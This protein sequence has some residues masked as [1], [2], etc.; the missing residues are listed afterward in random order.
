MKHL[1]TDALQIL[2]EAYSGLT[3]PEWVD[4]LHRKFPALDRDFLQTM[5][6]NFIVG[7]P[8]VKQMD[9]GGSEVVYVHY[10]LFHKSRIQE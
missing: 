3:L 1:E 7:N 10:N 5:L 6:A 4:F 9:T 8:Y 2:H